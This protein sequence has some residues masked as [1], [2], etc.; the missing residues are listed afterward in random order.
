MGAIEI[1]FFEIR[2]DALNPFHSIASKKM[3][4]VKCILDWQGI[5]AFDL[6]A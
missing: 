2:V 3:E 4:Q 5:A 1:A 6:P